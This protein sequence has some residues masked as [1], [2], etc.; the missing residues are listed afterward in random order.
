[1][2]GRYHTNRVGIFLCVTLFFVIL[3]RWLLLLGRILLRLLLPSEGSLIVAEPHKLYG[4]HAPI[5]LSKTSD[6]YACVLDN[7]KSLSGV[8]GKPE[9]SIIYNSHRINK[10]VTTTLQYLL[11]NFISE[12]GRI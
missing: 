2:M 3:R 1:M 5:L 12:C 7:L 6:G 4:P 9:S 10:G 8:L 11:Q